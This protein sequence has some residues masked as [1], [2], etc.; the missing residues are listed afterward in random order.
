V[1]LKDRAYASLNKC[2]LSRNDFCFW[3]WEDV[4]LERGEGDVSDAAAGGEVSD[5]AAGG[6]DVKGGDVT[7]AALEL[8]KILVVLDEENGEEVSCSHRDTHI[9]MH[10][11]RDT[12]ILMHTQRYTH[13]HAHTQRYTHTHAHTEIH[14]YSCTHT[15]THIL[16]HTHRYTHTHAHTQI[17][18][19]SHA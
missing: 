9:L 2:V 11:H 19:Y 3:A 5:A 7:N 8:R 17:H 13:T 16:M 6:E 14:T 10:T 18:T 15:D 1:F 12:H 4:M